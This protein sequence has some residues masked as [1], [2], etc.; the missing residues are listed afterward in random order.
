MTSAA[1]AI[2]AYG[3]DRSAARTPRQDEY[4]VFARVTR[5]LA[6][7]RDDAARDFPRL[8]A[9]LHDN[10]RLWT[11]LAAD[12]ALETNGLPEGLRAKLFYLAEFTRAHSRKVLDGEA[13]AGALVD[14]NTAIMRGLRSAAE[15]GRCPA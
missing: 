5:E 11:A 1:F 6:A 2:N 3:D 7:A 13:D 14:V 4:R 12:V 9:A 8:A 10:Q 15:P